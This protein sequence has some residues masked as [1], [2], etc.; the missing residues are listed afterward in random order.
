M[1]QILHSIPSTMNKMETEMECSHGTA[2]VVKGRREE[3]NVSV[4]PNS[5]IVGGLWLHCHL[6]GFQWIGEMAYI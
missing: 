5:V 4:R 2:K 3:P 1:F 6:L